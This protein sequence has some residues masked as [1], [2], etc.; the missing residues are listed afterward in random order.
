MTQSI[1]PKASEE[2]PILVD[3]D[4]EYIVSAKP[5]IEKLKKIE[6]EGE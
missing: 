5:L 6:K 1:L 3:I 4:I 2:K